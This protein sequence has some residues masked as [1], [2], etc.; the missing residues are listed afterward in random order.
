M[1]PDRAL[2]K[3]NAR[4]NGKKQDK[5]EL[6]TET[7]SVS[8]NLNNFLSL[9]VPLLVVRDLAD[10]ESVLFFSPQ[11]QLKDFSEISQ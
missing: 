1:G 3:E 8:I 11:S 6:N 2:G 4:Y 9:P 5:S 7:H 10:I